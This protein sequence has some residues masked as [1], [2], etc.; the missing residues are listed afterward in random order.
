M[1]N[2]K[3]EDKYFFL[4]SQ[5]VDFSKLDPSLK[6]GERIKG[7]DYKDSIKILGDFYKHNEIT[8][9]NGRPVDIVIIPRLEDA[10]LQFEN[11]KKAEKQKAYTDLVENP[12]AE[13]ITLDEEQELIRDNIRILQT[14]LANWGDER[15]GVVKYHREN[16]DYEVS[17]DRYEV[18]TA[19][20]TKQSLDADGNVIDEEVNEGSLE[21]KM[22]AK[23]GTQSLQQM[24][25]KETTYIIKSLFKVD[26]DGTTP[27]DRF[28]FKERVDF[29]KIF[30]ILAKTIGGERDRYVAYEKLREEAAKFPEIRQ[31]Y[32]KKY[33]DPSAPGNKYEFDISKQFWLDFAKYRVRYRQLFAYYDKESGG[34]DFKVKES[35]IAIDNT[36]NRWSS[37]FKS[38]LPTE[39]ISKSKENI[40]SLNLNNVVNKFSTKGELKPENGLDF[41]RAIA[42]DMDKN[43]NIQQ[44]LI[45]NFDYYGLDYIFDIVKGFNEIEN[46]RASSP[47]D[48]RLTP[49]RLKYLELFKANPIDVLKDTIPAGVLSNITGAVKELTQLKRLAELQSK[50]GFDSATTGVIRANGNTGYQE[51]NW[52][53]ATAYSYALNAVTNMNELWTD[54][55][56]SYMSYLNPEINPY[57]LNLSIIKSLFNTTTG[58]KLKGKSVE[59][60]AVD[61][62]SMSKKT[63]VMKNGRAVD[64][65]EA[66]GNTTTELDPYSKFL[67]ELHTMT[68]G[69]VAEFPRHSEKK[70]SYGLK[71]IGGI[72]GDTVGFYSKGVD[73]NLYVDINKFF[74]TDEK[75]RSEG[76]LYAIGNNLFPYLQS[77]FDRIKKFRGPNKDQYLRFTG[78]NRTV[79]DGNDVDVPQGSVFVAFDGVLR[80]DTKNALY[81]LADQQID[82]PLVDYLR[83]NKLK[84]EIFTDIVDYFDEKTKSL[85]DLYFQKMP[86]LSKS[87]YEK[88]GYTADQLTAQKLNQLRSDKD[89]TSKILKAYSYNDWIHKFETSTLLYGDHAQWNHEKEDWSKRIPGLTSD[90]IGFLFDKG[91]VAFINDY[92]NTNSYAK[93][94]S[95][96]ETNYDNFRYSEKLN[97]AIIKDAVRESVYLDDYLEAWRE[98]YSAVYKDKALI[99]ELLAKDAK[100]YEGMKEGDGMAYM[101]FDAYRTLHETGRGWSMAQEDLYQKIIRGERVDP[102]TVK[103]GFPVYKLHY[104]GAI[105]ND[106]LPA[107]AMHK[108]SVIPL[109]PGV[110]AKEGSQLDVLHKKMMKENVQYITFDTGSKGSNL[111]ADGTLDNIFANKEDKSINE[112]VPFTINPIYMSNLKE[113]TVINEYF[114]GSLP[115]ATQTR[116][117]LLDNLFSDGKLLNSDHAPVVNEYLSAVKEYSEILKDELLNEIGFE[118]IDGRYVGNLTQFIEVLR[119]ELKNRDTPEHLIRLLNTTEDEQLA[120]DLS[121]HP[122]AD[123]VEKIIMSFLQNGLIKQKTNGEPLVQTPTTFTNGLWDAQFDSITDPEEIKKVLG[124]NTLPFYLTNKD[125][126]GKRAV[127]DLKQ[128]LK[129]RRGEC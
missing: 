85:N 52:S 64:V 11:Y 97:T 58:E 18:E 77:E 36:L 10:Q 13:A 120:M 76:D 44:E 53:A 102:K 56:Y 73:K 8:D 94:I 93:T 117:I 54:P 38:T 46:L 105:A 69:G 42:I 124:S 51:M 99:E 24:M 23:T 30:T 74:K 116:G 113:V 110:N 17:K 55:R 33:P 22:E 108:F 3:G 26:P 90:G 5:V 109:I 40:S 2:K 122:E 107:T 129:G 28:G 14:T 111:T 104:F 31:L 112:D 21:N 121:L 9:E 91:T 25:S 114:K 68:L 41:A 95:T 12:N 125:E 84:G 101:T 43:D 72:E 7:L 39:F 1:K 118:L 67:Q 19:I 71:V 66:A 119:D 128:F 103:E 75:G 57:T 100:A 96:A 106:I 83:G 92:F 88:I 62:T 47:Q 70:F 45:A 63:T 123:N 34:I 60:M 29:N 78:Y 48:P 50:Y 49:E 86:Y 82:V 15:S 32:E 127:E 65:E 80:Q 98:E 79:N 37:L 115:I 61:G 4:T 81:E 20:E 59:L 35:S 6:R 126:N 27:V 89:I 16:T 87:M